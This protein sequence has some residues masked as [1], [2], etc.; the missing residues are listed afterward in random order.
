M[1]YKL[2]TVRI[3]V[4]DW[5]RSLAFYSDTL[6]IPI[7]YA[8][9]ESGWAELETGEAHLALERVA[10][11][12]PEA[13][14]LVGRFVSVSLEVDD[15]QAVYEKLIS[16]GVEFL[17]PPEKQPWGGSLAHFRDPDGNVLTILGS[18]SSD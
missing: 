15:L 1:K 10:P 18:G 4:T 17:A 7:A 8:I 3:F 2:K 14:E 16:R 11:Q 5:T 9:P 12:D 13:D 6:G